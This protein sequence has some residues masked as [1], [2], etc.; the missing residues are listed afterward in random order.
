MA[1]ELGKR[2]PGK[3]GEESAKLREKPTKLSERSGRIG[4][5]PGRFRE[6]REEPEKLGNRAER[7]GERPENVLTGVEISVW[8]GCRDW[9][10]KQWKERY[11][12]G[13][14]NIQAGNLL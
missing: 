5:R 10:R 11:Q 14:K 7:F 13:L 9:G 8:K 6:L 4:E 12:N 2:Q 1:G 3:L